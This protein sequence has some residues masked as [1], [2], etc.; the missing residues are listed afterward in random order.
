MRQNHGESRKDYPN[1]VLFTEEFCLKF[2]KGKYE[3]LHSRGQMGEE[4]KKPKGFI[5]FI[6]NEKGK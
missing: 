6:G 3:V 2:E 1:F 5:H 4:E